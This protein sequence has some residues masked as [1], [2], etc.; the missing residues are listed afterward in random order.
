MDAKNL[1]SFCVLFLHFNCFHCQSFT[2]ICPLHWLIINLIRDSFEFALASAAAYD[3]LFICRFL[4]SLK[5]VYQLYLVRLY[6][7]T[8]F[9]EH[10]CM[11]IFLLF[12]EISFISV[13]YP[14]HFLCISCAFFFDFLFW[15]PPCLH[16]NGLLHMITYFHDWHTWFI[17]QFFSILFNSLLFMF[18]RKHLVRIQHPNHFIFFFFFIPIFLCFC[19]RF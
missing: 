19:I 2:S 1:L 18:I 16:V 14:M 4:F 5:F 7:W 6:P 13:D 8:V 3:C 9:I 15:F 11:S 12:K 10:T 17:L